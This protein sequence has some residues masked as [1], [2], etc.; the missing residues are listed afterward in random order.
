[1]LLIQFIFLQFC[2]LFTTV[3][4]LNFGVMEANPVVRA[5]LGLARAYPTLGLVALKGVGLAC[6]FYA[7]RT[8]RHRLLSRINLLFA[9]CVAWN[10][11]AIVVS[12]T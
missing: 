5:V 3:V 11:V 7:W 8:G 4:F 6:G 9:A 2:D 1:M 10:V 12:V